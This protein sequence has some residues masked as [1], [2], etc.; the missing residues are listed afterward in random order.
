MFPFIPWPFALGVIAFVLTLSADQ[1]SKYWILYDIDLPARGSIRV[2]P[3]LNFTMVWNRA[4]TF[5]MF[6]WL[7]HSGRFIFSGISLAVVCALWVWMYRTP[8][9]LT[10]LCVGTIAGGAIGN[11]IDRLCYGAVV[12]FLHA[13]AFG[14][15]WYVF[16]VAD[17]AIVCSVC[18]LL[19][20][21][22]LSGHQQV[23]QKSVECSVSDE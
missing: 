22:F 5:G 3:F 17:S 16:N 8:Y 1:L 21:N 11:V 20:Q 15:S 9:K 2:L 7:G 23:L 6:G 13:H 14:W 10:A 18:I 19:V 4:I 12:D